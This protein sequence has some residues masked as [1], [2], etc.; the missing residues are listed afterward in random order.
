MGYPFFYNLPLTCTLR[1]VSIFI[2]F[3][4]ILKTNN[5]IKFDLP[6]N[7]KGQQG[8]AAHERDK[9]SGIEVFKFDMIMGWF[10]FVS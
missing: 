10:G 5:Y 1:K 4:F 9:E 6:N 7:G 3:C 2:S 8:R